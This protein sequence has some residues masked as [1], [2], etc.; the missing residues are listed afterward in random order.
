VNLGGLFD[1]LAPLGKG[2]LDPARYG[3]HPERV[4]LPLQLNALALQLR[5]KRAAVRLRALGAVLAA[6]DMAAESCRAAVLDCRH[7]LHLVEA[8]YSSG[9][10]RLV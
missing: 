6:R 2:P 5:G 4:L 8:E 7:H 10:G 1:G 9:G 3:R